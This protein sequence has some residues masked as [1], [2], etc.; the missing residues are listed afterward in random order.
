[1]ILGLNSFLSV[2]NVLLDLRTDFI[3][4]DSLVIVCFR[5]MTLEFLFS[6]FQQKQESNYV[7]LRKKVTSNRLSMLHRLTLREK[8]AHLPAAHKDAPGFMETSNF[9]GNSVKESYYVIP[10]TVKVPIQP[11]IIGSLP[12]A[13]PESFEISTQ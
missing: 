8:V 4:T 12:R 9:N 3:A 2:V 1:M 5:L 11:R 6:T 7:A 13:E 10:R